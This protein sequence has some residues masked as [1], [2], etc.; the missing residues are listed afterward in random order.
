MRIIALSHTE[1][2]RELSALWVA[3]SSAVDF[4]LGCSPNETF[5]MEFVDELIAV[6]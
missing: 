4:V 6:F 1:M 5:W 3:V 2:A